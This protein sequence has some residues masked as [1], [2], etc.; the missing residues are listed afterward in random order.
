MFLF[1]YMYDK[2]KLFGG[3]H[4]LKLLLCRNDV[5]FFFT[6]LTIA[7]ANSRSTCLQPPLPSTIQPFMQRN[8][9][10]DCK[11]KHTNCTGNK[12]PVFI[13]IWRCVSF[14]FLGNKQFELRRNWQTA[15]SHSFSCLLFSFQGSSNV[16]FITHKN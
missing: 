2:Y 9:R 6:C 7:N 14:Y 3:V 16:R 5:S 11:L 12:S 1:R 4:N 8:M 10:E 15:F 13:S